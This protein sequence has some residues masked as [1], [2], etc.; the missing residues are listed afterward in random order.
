MKRKPNPL[1]VVV[2]IL[3]LV[4]CSG[5]SVPIAT[6]LPEATFTPFQTQ[7]SSPTFTLTP[8]PTST[9][10]PTLTP[11]VTPR[12][13]RTPMPTATPFPEGF[14]VSKDF[15]FSIVY[16]EGWRE[17]ST[18]DYFQLENSNLDLA[19]VGISFIE[20]AETPFRTILTSVRS[21]QWGVFVNSKVDSQFTTS[22]ADG[23]KAQVAIVNGKSKYDQ[24]VT[25][26]LATARQG[27]RTYVFY[28]TSLTQDFLDN[29]SDIEKLFKSIR[30]EGVQLY[31]AAPD[32]TLVLYGYGDPY[33][34]DLD[35]ALTGSGAGGLVGLLYSGLVSLTP[36][37]K[38]VPDLA[39]S[40]TVSTDGTVY[41]FTLRYDLAFQDE[42]PLT[43]EDVKYSWERAT[44]PKTGSA[45]AGT[46]L[47]DIVGVKEKLSGRAE[48][49]S[50]VQVIDDHTLVVK[51][52]GPKPYFLAKLTYPSSFVVDEKSVNAR[53]DD[54]LYEP[55]A[56][57]PFKL[58]EYEQGNI[59]LL[60]RNLAYHQP[61]KLAYIAFMLAYFDN[62]LKYYEEDVIDIAD[63]F[64]NEEAA[65]IL[66]A[67]YPLYDEVQSMPSMCTD[68]LLMN[69]TIPPMD[70][71][72]VRKAFAL[73]IDRQRLIDQFGG[74][75]YIIADTILP[76]AMPGFSTDLKIDP[77]D[78]K[79]AKEALAA[80]GYAA[81]LPK[82]V[83]SLSG[84]A[85]EPSDYA[86]AIV[87][88]WKKNIGVNVEVE[89]L[90]P[91]E[92][93][94]TAHEQHGQIVWYGWCADYP[95]PQNFLDIL[96]YT[97]SDFN[98]SGYTNSK[99]DELLEQAR[100]EGDATRRL[101]LYKNVEMILL[102]DYAA[103]PLD[104]QIYTILVKPKV[105]GVIL[106]PTGGRYL[107]LVW[108]EN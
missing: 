71:P 41:T 88:M 21:S 65:K 86:N 34:E 35:P 77:F 83:L 98:V 99:I 63:W 75:N 20:E 76:P 103:I 97:G 7:I 43:A 80:S 17:S 90:D 108:L 64:A 25:L 69:N 16:G 73:A 13:T 102:N 74:A 2:L 29:Q 56:S 14:V 95:D 106:S 78:P 67:D 87:A 10:T 70:D 93:S 6:T 51:L 84:Y 59:I 101:E 55:N 50:G 53:T 89:Y 92:Y 31:G 27:S 44:D 15:A 46:Y 81:K 82:V 104:H 54:W 32:Q 3:S 68:M 91:T 26:Y 52:D 30:L 1:F 4:A 72:N 42:S 37:E 33:P 22:L 9:P 40:W 62:P 85:N 5:P 48:E 45:M 60:E 18:P 96:F 58:L 107:D 8:L 61:P 49:I 36:D 94:K 105:K 39:E 12:P 57:G 28:L 23:S 11:T 47:G 66:D 79:A 38:I 24:F 19:F 100:V